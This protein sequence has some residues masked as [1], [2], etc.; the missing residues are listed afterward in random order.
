MG[1][2]A[3]T[4]RDPL[5]NQLGPD[6]RRTVV[7]GALAEG[8]APFQDGLGIPQPDSGVHLLA[9]GTYRFTLTVSALDVDDWTLELWHDGEF[10]THSAIS[11][12]VRITEGPTPT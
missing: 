2:L 4:H 12:H 8:S 6:V 7:L 11:E 3:W 9:P 10:D 1:P 5:L